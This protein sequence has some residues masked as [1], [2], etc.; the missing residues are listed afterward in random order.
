MYTDRPSATRW[1]CQELFQNM[2]SFCVPSFF[3]AEV[4]FRSPAWSHN[5]FSCKGQNEGLILILSSKRKSICDTLW[6]TRHFQ[7]FWLLFFPDCILWHSNT[8]DKVLICP[9]CAKILTLF[10]AVLRTHWYIRVSVHGDQ[11]LQAAVNNLQRPKSVPFP[12]F[13][14]GSKESHELFLSSRQWVRG[15]GVENLHPLNLFQTVLRQQTSRE[16]ILT[17]RKVCC[18]W[19]PTFF[20]RS[21]GH[22]DR[23]WHEV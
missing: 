16:P 23:N 13:F 17:S 14:T 10:N 22:R 6:N 12:C 7:A 2:T 9:N 8:A 20:P 3:E 21:L 11:F 4:C 5:H 18:R 19:R 15:L 1:H